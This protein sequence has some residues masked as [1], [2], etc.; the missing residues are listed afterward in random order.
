MKVLVTGGDGQLGCSLK[1]K[2]VDYPN[3]EM[4]FTDVGDLDITNKIELESYITKNPVDYLVNC[5]AYTAV[6]KAEEDEETAFLLNKLA[7]ENLAELSVQFNFTLIQISTDYVFS[8]H[9]FRPY[10]EE[11]IPDPNGVYALSKYEGEKAVIA[12]TKTGIVL[13]TSWLYSEYGN[14]FF[15][16]VLRLADENN[17]LRMIGDQIGTPTYAGEL[18]KAIFEIIHN[19][20]S[21]KSILHFSNEGVASWYDF[22]HEVIQLS[23]KG[24]KVIP[25]KTEEYPLP[26][27][28]PFYS[29]MSK[30]KFTDTFEYYIPH[31]KEGLLTCLENMNM[32]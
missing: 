15:K 20:Y 25:I 21:E 5:A 7:V 19:E 23:D 18:A 4:I 16:T 14:N 26:A 6:D 31:W 2:I 9:H 27:P 3:I 32:K 12:K 28:R 1:D 22:A 10:N 29:V 8:G 11:D 30:K 24:C 13:R 17:E